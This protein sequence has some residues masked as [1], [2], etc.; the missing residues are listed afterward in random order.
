MNTRSKRGFRYV[1]RVGR[2]NFG[3]VNPSRADL[4]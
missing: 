1:N 3:F 4:R 2:Q